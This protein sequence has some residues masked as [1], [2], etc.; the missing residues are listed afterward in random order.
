MNDSRPAWLT[1]PNLITIFRLAL[2]PVFV[3]LHLCGLAG[4]ALVCF[5]V[6]AGSDGI[7]GLLARLL[8]QRSKLGGILDPVADKVLVSAA[9]L[10]LMF[11]HRL[12]WFLIA[13]IAFRD[14]WMLIGAW[15]V[16][17]KNLEIPT[18]PTRIGKYATFSLTMVV[19]LALLDQALDTPPK[20]H[21]YLM[22]T[23]FVATL[24]VVVST[25][26][27]FARFGYLFFAPAKRATGGRD[28]EPAR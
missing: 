18:A 17:H 3:V 6:A 1:I 5:G 25:I 19:V 4:W 13:L 2:V 10:T 23:G 11:E 28:E 12:P 24:C 26:Q 21:A 27:Y 15:V 9:L 16:K 7:D 20:L 8:N 22:V 14:G